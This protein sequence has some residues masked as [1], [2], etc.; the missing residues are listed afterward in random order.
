MSANVFAGNEKKKKNSKCHR[1]MTRPRQ[2][3]A[4][5]WPKITARTAVTFLQ[6]Y[7]LTE[8]ARGAGPTITLNLKLHS[9]GINLGQLSSN[10]CAAFSEAETALDVTFSFS[11]VE[12]MQ[13]ETCCDTERTMMPINCLFLPLITSFL[14]D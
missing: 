2:E 11:K 8:R 10:N 4:A 1:F 13:L 3:T 12:V 7:T 9:P 5:M 6:C 14:C